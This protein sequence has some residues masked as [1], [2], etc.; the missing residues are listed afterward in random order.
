MLSKHWL[1]H[2]IGFTGLIYL[3]LAIPFQDYL[4]PYPAFG[5]LLF[6]LILSRKQL[7]TNWTPLSWI[8]IGIFLLALLLAIPFTETSMKT[9][10]KLIPL[11]ITACFLPYLSFSREQIHHV[12]QVF[13]VSIGL[14]FYLSLIAGLPAYFQNGDTS[15]FFYMKLCVFLERQ[16]HYLALFSAC[17]IM[18]LGSNALPSIKQLSK[19][20]QIGLGLLT[21]SLLAFLMMLSARAQIFSFAIVAFFAVLIYFKQQGKTRKGILLGIIALTGFSLA[22]LSSPKARERLENS[23][24]KADITIDET[25][26]E[27][28]RII[29][30]NTALDLILE[31]PLLG[32]GTGKA[33]KALQDK[34]AEEGHSI[35]KKK[36][37]NYHNQYLQAWASNGILG[38]LL[39]LSLLAYWS[40]LLWKN[41]Q[42]YLI[43]SLSL[44]CLSMLTESMLQR[45]AGVIFM[46]FLLLSTLDS[47]SASP[48]EK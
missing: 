19:G 20:K 15:Q 25:G 2:N 44:F 21:I 39:L 47:K 38:L 46:C 8:S 43:A 33:N 41:K 9:V 16:P 3:A 18:F 6:Q 22:V 14:S 31:K 1:R 13:A 10:Q 30:W 35:L 5:L 17:A 11:F 34:A 27:D 32:H 40:R 45:Q 7:N 12:W 28:P 36:K 24:Q 37:L 26:K 48:Y 4:S 23:F 42:W 29:T